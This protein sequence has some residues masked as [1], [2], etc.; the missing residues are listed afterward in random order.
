MKNSFLIGL[1]FTLFGFISA[2]STFTFQY[3][4]KIK[5]LG[6]Q[7]SLNEETNPFEEYFDKNPDKR[8]ESYTTALWRGY[9]GYFE[10]IEQQLFLTDITRPN[11]KYELTEDKKTQISFFKEIARSQDKFKVEWYNDILVFSKDEY[12]KNGRDYF[13]LEIKK[14]IL[15]KSKNLTYNELTELKER[16]LIEFQ[17]TDDYNIRFKSL[18][19][20]FPDKDDVF[21]RNYIKNHILEYITEFLTD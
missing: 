17:K 7:Y 19:N 15:T 21:I 1:I 6:I 18:K 14:G 8:P 16:L 4:D 3:P 5:Y 12:T 11:P 9:I 2:D 10:I 13:L 20:S